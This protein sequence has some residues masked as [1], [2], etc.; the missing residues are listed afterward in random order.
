QFL[1][2]RLDENDEPQILD[3]TIRF[4]PNNE[5]NIILLHLGLA[6]KNRKIY[7]NVKYQNHTLATPYSKIVTIDFSESRNS[8]VKPWKYMV[9]RLESYGDLDM[10]LWVY[11]IRHYYEVY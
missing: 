2:K 6:E 10:A 8:R 7:C 9:E 5:D 3:P 11:C 4:T 1:Q